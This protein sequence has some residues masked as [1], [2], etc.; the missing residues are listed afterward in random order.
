MRLILFGPPGAGKGTQADFIR[1]KY[2]VEHI[3]TGDVLREAVK[4]GTEV[5]LYAKS[6]M[7]KGE[8]VPDE[9]VT[10]IIR[11]KISTLGEAGFMLDGFP[12]TLEQA[13]CLEDILTGAG[14]AIDAVIFLEVPDQEVIQRIIR[15]QKIE[16]RQD[17]TED[18]IKNRL[19]VYKDQTSPLKDFYEGTGVLHAVEGV[20]E[21]SDIAVRVEGVLKNL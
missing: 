8:L 10:E 19:R 12:R 5:G 15:R 18:L 7:D 2:G 17:D 11:Q 3:S 20:G 21:I 16:G 13:K 4:N 14:A 6:F 9:V 1:E